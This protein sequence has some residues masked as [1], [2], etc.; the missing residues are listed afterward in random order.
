M[1]AV[2]HEDV[3]A[4]TVRIVVVV[5]GI[6]GFIDV[7]VTSHHVVERMAMI[8]IYLL[9]YMYGDREFLSAC[10]T[11]DVLECSRWHLQLN[12]ISCWH[13]P[14][15]EH[16]FLTRF[17]H[18]QCA[19]H[20][21][22]CLL[23]RA[24][25][26]H[27]DDTISRNVVNFVGRIG[28]FLS[29]Y[30]YPRKHGR[31]VRRCQLELYGIR[32]HCYAVARRHRY[33]TFLRGDV[34]LG[35]SHHAVASGCARHIRH[36]LIG[37]FPRRDSKGE[38]SVIFHLLAY[39][40][41]VKCGA[42]AGDGLDGGLRY[43]LLL[44]C[45]AETAEVRT[46]HK[47]HLQI[48]GVGF[49]FSLRLHVAYKRQRLALYLHRLVALIYLLCKCYLCQATRCGWESD[50]S[51]GS[52]LHAFRMCLIHIREFS[53]RS[54][55]VN[56]DVYGFIVPFQLRDKDALRFFYVYG[57]R[58]VVGGKVPCGCHILRHVQTVKLV[59]HE[60]REQTQVA[61]CGN[62]RVADIIYVATF[63]LPMVQR[64]ALIE[65][66]AVGGDYKGVAL[67]HKLSNGRRT[68]RH[69]SAVVSDVVSGFLLKVNH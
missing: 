8:F 59:R 1:R 26:S 64:V 54:V 10:I 50:D 30:R 32:L 16:Q 51:T 48:S 14:I 56:L 53:F 34:S 68:H 11:I 5:G 44:V 49:A 4:V 20:V 31:R 28:V 42:V 33:V 61:R 58:S 36:L 69:L 38:I 47:L 46:A 6:D 29:A 18:I 37:V 62:I 57:R 13:V 15:P 40:I 35:G 25:E 2:G 19:V 67:L 65:E 66:R 41:C 3:E 55:K 63:V 52:N 43:V 39:L 22:Q 12:D 60:Y 45:H 17:R 9:R 24:V 23:H 7:T 21:Q 27:S